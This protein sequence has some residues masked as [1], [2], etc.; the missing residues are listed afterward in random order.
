MIL[1]SL[2]NTEGLANLFMAA[3]LATMA[4]SVILMSQGTPMTFEGAARPP[5]SKARSRRSRAA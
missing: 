5:R 3:F 1:P 4:V 2:Q